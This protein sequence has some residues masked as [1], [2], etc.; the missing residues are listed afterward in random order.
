MEVNGLL[1]EKER[2]YLDNKYQLD[3][4]SGNNSLLSLA[5]QYIRKNRTILD[6]TNTFSA[7]ETNKL[8]QIWLQTP[9]CKF[10]QMGKC[11]ICNY[12]A[13]Q[14]I[15]GL[16]TQMQKSIVIPQNVNTILI[17]TCGSCL[18]TN[19]LT[20]GEQELL[21]QWLNEQAVENIILETHMSTLSEYT[22]QR[23]RKILPHKRLFFEIG[24]ESIDRDVQFYS[25]NKP[26]SEKGRSVIIDRLH[27]YGAGCIINVVLGAP[28]LNEEE[29]VWDAIESINQ[30]LQENTDYIMLFP[31]NIKPNTLVYILYKMGLYDIVD[32]NM[33]AKVLDA[34]PEK[35]LPKVDVA[36]YGE[37]QESGVISPYIPNVYKREF[38]AILSAY[39]SSE[40]AIERKQQVKIL[41]EKG[42]SWKLEDRKLTT[43]SSFVERLDKAYQLLYERIP[44]FKGNKT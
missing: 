9:V 15:P 27:R 31:V 28:F 22:V 36:W 40:S 30:L 7:F 34:L 39:N 4:T 24:Q 32:S 6:S 2:I 10:S 17:N 16:I 26:L 21:L 19:E 43:E 35:F 25:L 38:L 29:Q 41:R 3:H 23:V 20:I 44:I 5:M 11:T 8:I 37:H 33:I 18:D 13:G 1:I 42:N 14:K 12:W